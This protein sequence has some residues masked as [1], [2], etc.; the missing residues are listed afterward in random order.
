MDEKRTV[1]VA[2][3]AKQINAEV[4]GAQKYRPSF[5]GNALDSAIPHLFDAFWRLERIPDEKGALVRVIRTQENFNS[6]ARDRSGNLAE[7]DAPDL[8]YLINKARQ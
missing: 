5:P 8:T 7:L 4:D 3:L 1:N 2:I 6:F